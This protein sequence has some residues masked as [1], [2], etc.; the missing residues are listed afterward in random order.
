[1]AITLDILYAFAFES[2]DSACLSAGMNFNLLLA[3]ERGNFDFRSQGS[4]HKADLH[5]ADQ[6]V[7]FALKDLVRFDVQHH[8]EIARRPPTHA[9]LSIPG[10]PE[11]CAGIHACGN[12]Q[13]D[14]GGL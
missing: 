14:L 13:G 6:V 12:A 11:P 1:M 8:I 5:F 7:A 9:S 3:F 4:L 10:G 2:K